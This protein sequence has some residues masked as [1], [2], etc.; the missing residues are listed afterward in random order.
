MVR[1]KS[2]VRSEHKEQLGGAHLF[3][4]DI[5]KA[6]GRGIRGTILCDFGVKANLLV[7]PH[8]FSEIGAI[9]FPEHG[10]PR[11]GAIRIEA[12]SRGLRHHFGQEDAGNDWKPGEMITKQF[13]VCR[14]RFGRHNL[15]SRIQFVNTIDQDESHVSTVSD[16]RSIFHYAA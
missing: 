13:L 3:A 6:I 10:S 16:V 15:L 7:R 11:M 9:D 14:Q 8:P 2:V 12:S 1:C 4:L 5:G